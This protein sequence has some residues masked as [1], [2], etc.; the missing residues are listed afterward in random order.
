MYTRR[1]ARHGLPAE[2]LSLLLLGVILPP[3]CA[4]PA[5]PGH[6]QDTDWA[7]ITLSD[8]SAIS[9]R[10][11]AEA[12]SKS[13]G[14]KLLKIRSDAAHCAAAHKGQSRNMDRFLAIAELRVEKACLLFNR[15]YRPANLRDQIAE[16]ELDSA[17]A[18][19]SD[20]ERGADLKLA[21][22]GLIESAYYSEIDGSP[23]PYVYY[24]PKRK[25]ANG[26]FGLFVFL[27]G[28]AGDLDKVNWIMY[29]YSD[30]LNSLADELGLI[31]ILPFGRS[32]TEFMG[33]GEVDVLAAI[34]EMKRFYPIDDRRVFMSGGSMGG[35]GNYTIACH[36]PHLIAGIAPIAGRY[37]Y[38]L[39][40]DIDRDTYTGF[41][42]IQT[43][44]DYAEAMPQNLYNVPAYIFHGGGDYLVKVEQS[45]GMSAL[46]RRLGQQ[47]EYKE[48]SDGD[49]WIWGR[50]FT[51]PPFV[52]WLRKTAAPPWPDT[53]K[54]KTY[55]LRYDRAY[56]AQIN[57]FERWGRPAYIHAAAGKDGA[58]VVSTRNVAELTLAA[59]EALVGQRDHV[60]LIVNGRTQ[61]ATIANGIVR[62]QLSKAQGS[63]LQKTHDV[64][65]SVRE[66]Y[67]SE[68]VMVFGT[69]AQGKRD[70]QNA[71][72]A[73]REWVS[74]AK[75]RAAIKPDTLVSPQDIAQRN[76]I[77]FGDAESNLVVRR[78]APKL[79][80]H[81]A[82]AEFVLAGRTFPRPES[83][84]LMVYPNP[85]NPARYVLLNVGA[86]WG[87]F[88][89]INH[90]LD[91][92][93]DFIVFKDS[94]ATDG[95]NEYLCAGYFD[96]NWQFSEELTW[97]AGKGNAGR[98][99]VE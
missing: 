94:R 40:K 39:W 60:R 98:A 80:L 12:A 54:F 64:C 66:P 46:L 85:L 6:A 58:I 95:N 24:L 79:P 28:Y 15:G 51:H 53:I 11:A 19:V 30:K 52:E 34:A 20:I 55:T 77:L 78:I 44:I 71:L 63:G 62:A 27:H 5:R 76:L 84:L 9:A 67:C 50:C 18:V 69:Q 88:L 68:F 17:A 65:G 93:P 29:M 82:Q 73:G 57:R 14:G 74:F 92:V 81:I 8:A 87:Q 90:K 3:V 43:D 23:Q 31:P 99:P 4:A 38:Y 47:V 22:R 70:M 35:S 21:D 16:Q 61:E 89:S 75:G 45:R 97:D 41:K 2:A 91:H 96:N 33:V 10:R 48:F 7:E 36:Y 72:K 32:N 56:W 59:D 86:F 25:P 26:R 83:S 1:H 37:S 42:R 13:L 49:H